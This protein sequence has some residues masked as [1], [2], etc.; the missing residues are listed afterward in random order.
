MC[1]CTSIYH[2]PLITMLYHH[3]V[4]GSSSRELARAR[5]PL[6]SGPSF[7]RRLR[8]FFEDARSPRPLPSK[9][10][11]KSDRAADRV[12]AH[13][14][15]SPRTIHLHVPRRFFRSSLQ[16]FVRWRLFFSPFFFL[17][18]VLVVNTAVGET[19]SLP[20]FLSV[21]LLRVS[22]AKSKRLARTLLA[23]VTVRTERVY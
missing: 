15:L 18:R 17:S 11:Q 8:L 5:T 23:Y 12:K 3:G 14:R 16:Q 20:F 7:S 22:R 6:P 4:R 13:E 1:M 19:D 21:C 9:A 10:A 2:S